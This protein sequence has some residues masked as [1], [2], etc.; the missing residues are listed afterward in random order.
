MVGH[1]RQYTSQ[2]GFRFAPTLS[3]IQGKTVVD[4]VVGDAR[5]ERYR[6]GEPRKTFIESLL[7][8]ENDSKQ[9]HGSMLGWIRCEPLPTGRLGLI[10]ATCCVELLRSSVHLGISLQK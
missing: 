6:L 5:I 1:V 8:T 10:E 2:D 4:P 9:V 7:A 3:F